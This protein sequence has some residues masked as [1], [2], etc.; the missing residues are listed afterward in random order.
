MRDGRRIL[1]ADAHVIEPAGVF[2]AAQTPGSEPMDLPPTTPRVPV[3]DLSK[4]D[5]FLASGASAA[6]YLRCLDKEGIDAV[7][8]YPSI[9]LFVPFQPELDPHVSAESCRAYN[10]WLA[11]YCATDPTRLTGAALVPVVDI[12]LA[13]AEAQHAATLDLP[14][15]MVRPNPLYGRTLGASDFDPL[16]SA[17][18]E[19]GLALAVHEGLGVRGPTIGRDRSDTFAIR[20]AMS[21]PMEQMA[22][23]AALMLEGSLER[24][25]GLRVAFLES[26]TGWLP[27]WLARLDG[28]C[29]WLHDTETK[30]LTLTPSEYFARQCVICTDPDDP[31]AAWVTSQV[32]AD[33]VMWASDFPHPDALYPDAVTSFLEESAEHALAGTDLDEVLWDA[34]VRFYRLEQRFAPKS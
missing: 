6:E 31:L 26:G 34:P 32:G 23:M 30:A 17:L 28:H 7:V 11:Q 5:D 1:D 27:Y 3:G 10:E 2:G 29:E 22:A 21:H 16:Y 19:T 33:H 18:E 14:V 25:P 9:G 12:D 13:V 24:H 4:L 20:H 15:V 8:L